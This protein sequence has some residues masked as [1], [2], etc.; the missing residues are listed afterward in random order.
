M[1]L[2]VNN[3][4]GTPDLE[5]GV[6]CDSLLA[7]SLGARAKYV[8]GPAR[9]M[10]ALDMKGVSVSV[11]PLDEAFASALTADSGAPAWPRVNEVRPNTSRSD[12]ARTRGRRGG[13]L[14]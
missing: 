10:T 8:L 7:T 13:P 12:A 14:G 5:M 6:F 4:G 9:L 3:L 11:L 1:A 2:L